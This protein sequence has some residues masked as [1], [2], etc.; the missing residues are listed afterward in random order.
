MTAK[1]S[2][3]KYEKF[4]PLTFPLSG[5]R[6]VEAS[7]GTGKTYSICLL[8]LRLL[9]EEKLKIGEILVVTFTKAA[10]GELKER[11]RKFILDAIDWCEGLEND[12]EQI[13]KILDKK[14]VR[15]NEPL[16][17]LKEAFLCIDEAAVFTI[18]GFC[19]RILGDN[20]F[21]TDSSFGTE[22]AG[23]DGSFAGEAVLDFYRKIICPDKSL[24]E[25][26]ADFSFSEFSEFAG[27]FSGKVYDV[28]FVHPDDI[29]AKNKYAFQGKML[30][31]IK[32]DLPARKKKQNVKTY[33]DL[34]TCTAASLE[35]PA[36]VK[37][38]CSRYRAAMIDEFQDT[39]PVQYSIFKTFFSAGNKKEREKKK[40]FLIGDPKQSIYRFR[41]ADIFSYLNAA[42][43]ADGIY[44]MNT[45]YR[46]APEFIEAVNSIFKRDN[47]F[48]MGDDVSYH[49]VD[50]GIKDEGLLKDKKNKGSLVIWK[51]SFKG[52]GE[53]EKGICEYVADEIIRL[54]AECSIGYKDEQSGKIKYRQARPGDI[55]VLVSTWKDGERIKSCLDDS[56]IPSAMNG[57]GNVFQSPEAAALKL[58]LR[59]FAEPKNEGF[60][61]GALCSGLIRISLKELDDYNQKDEV[62]ELHGERFLNCSRRWEKHGIL[63]ALTQFRKDYDIT[64]RIIAGERGE[65][66]LTNFN[67]LT[68]LLHAEEKSG[69]Y[70]TADLLT[71][72]NEQTGVTSG[73][74][75]EAADEKK[76]RLET[77]EA[78]V[79][80]TTIHGSKG[81]EYPIV[82]AP[83]LLKTG[84]PGNNNQN[85]VLY[86]DRKKNNRIY[87]KLGSYTN[88]VK[89]QYPERTD[90]QNQFIEENLW[91]NL[92]L[93]YV[94][95]TRAKY[96]CYLAWST[97]YKSNRAV[98]SNEPE[99]MKNICA[100]GYYLDDALK[101]ENKELEKYVSGLPKLTDRIYTPESSSDEFH[102]E[103]FTGE[104]SSDRKISSF[105]AISSSMK[106]S[107]Q[108]S[109]AYM[110]VQKEG[111]EPDSEQK[112]IFA[113]PKGSRAG[114][115]LHRIFE[116]TDFRQDPASPEYMEQVKELL[117]S[118]VEN[119]SWKYSDVVKMVQ[120]TLQAELPGQNFRLADIPM[121][122]RFSEMEFHFSV[123]EKTDLDLS[124]V[125]GC[126]DRKAG[127]RGFLTGFIDLVFQKNGKYY[128]V[129]WK[130][131]HLGQN[132]ENYTQDSLEDVMTS[133]YYHLQYLIY[134]LALHLYLKQRMSGYEYDKDFGGVFYVFLRGTGFGSGCGFY[135]VKPAF[136]QVEKLMKYFGMGEKYGR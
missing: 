39:D 5:T 135:H 95:V 114:T 71:W 29:E 131:N 2:E 136:S 45:N 46:S 10:A 72:F 85:Y 75:E 59:A 24:L 28:L 116:K 74:T 84:F 129:D 78:A 47:P 20:A 25:T 70:G 49:K 22:M 8:F 76:L 86:H 122:D 51:N 60:I 38:V 53:F 83:F 62:R 67:H 106:E 134:T 102:A 27:S 91:D 64:G 37:A 54:T 31:Y 42:K 90:E 130:S 118:Y 32:E 77:D 17:L 98:Y 120:D 105:T 55:A 113:F 11:I 108:A 104:I 15:E 35:N 125:K 26:D 57:S 40:L 97:D 124:F 110:E 117:P 121:K 69:C 79:A 99:K 18:H 50:A 82:F 7:A 9:L 101:G 13:K 44:S 112:G 127:F 63:A 16:K 65:R 92:R 132:R 58:I 66:T 36:F 100:A 123:P 93:A 41:G 119:D 21:E 14:T 1:T 68:E 19:Q 33:N 133:H 103:T 94:A 34:L 81:L 61:K 23:D 3:K 52:K 126:S 48:F 73:D 111:T 4:D 96:R 128:I 43:D 56:G 6:L 12:N 88:T 115:D 107:E 30:E 80:I 89:E 87:L 109:A